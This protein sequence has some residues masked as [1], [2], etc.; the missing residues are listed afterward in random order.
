MNFFH[1]QS[2]KHDHGDQKTERR[3]PSCYD[4]RQSQTLSETVHQSKRLYISIKHYDKEM[5]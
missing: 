2:S 5:Q 4:V 1:F 3:K